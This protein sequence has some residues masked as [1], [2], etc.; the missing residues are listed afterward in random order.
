MLLVS[1]HLTPG[2]FVGFEADDQSRDP[3]GL[4]YSHVFSLY[5]GEL[6]GRGERKQT[7]LLLVLKP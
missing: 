2:T 5:Q 4:L 7:G 3:N 1:P 6:L